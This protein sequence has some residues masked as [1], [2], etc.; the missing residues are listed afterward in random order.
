MSPCPNPVRIPTYT[1]TVYRIELLPKPTSRGPCRHDP[2]PVAGSS[3]KA[4]R[5]TS[6]LATGI[7]EGDRPNHCHSLLLTSSPL[8]TVSVLHLTDYGR[9]RAGHVFRC[10]RRC[11]SLPLDLFSV[12]TGLSCTEKTG[13]HVQIR[14]LAAGPYVFLLG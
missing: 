11:F 14:I 2:L 9:S 7:G 4:N 3:I 10:R 8:G 12:A 13:L 6:L 5:S 1:Y